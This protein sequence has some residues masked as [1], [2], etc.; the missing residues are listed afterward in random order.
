MIRNIP[1]LS[2][3]DVNALIKLSK[4]K[5]P[6]AAE[7]HYQK[8]RLLDLDA[9]K[10]FFEDSEVISWQCITE[11]SA[12]CLGY[13]FEKYDLAINDDAKDATG[14]LRFD[15]LEAID[16]A[17]ADVFGTYSWGLLS[18]NGLQTLS[19]DCAKLLSRVPWGQLQLNGLGAL[20]PMGFAWLYTT[21]DGVSLDGLRVLDLEHLNARPTGGGGGSGGGP[22]WSIG[23]NGIAY[24][25]QA[26]QDHLGEEG[27]CCRDE[28]KQYA[29]DHWI[30]LN[31]LRVLNSASLA[32]EAIL[33]Q[34]DVDFA[35]VDVDFTKLESVTFDAVQAMVGLKRWR[36]E[37][38]LP[39]LS[40]L[41]PDV[42]AVFCSNCD[43]IRLSGVR[44][45]SDATA[46][47]LAPFQGEELA[48]DGVSRLSEV[49][50][51][52]LCKTYADTLSLGGLVTL[53]KRQ[54][55]IIAAAQV[56]TMSL[57]S[58]SG[59]SQDV[60]DVLRTAKCGLNLSATLQQ[61]GD[62][63]EITV[64]E[65]LTLIK[66]DSP[67]WL[68]MVTNVTEEVARVLVRYEGPALS[69]FGLTAM[70]QWLATILGDCK[71]AT[72]DLRGLTELPGPVAKGLVKY[73]GFLVL[74]GIAHLSSIALDKLT[75]FR[76]NGISLRGI[77]RATPEELRKLLSIRGIELRPDWRAS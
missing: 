63:R 13:C 4:S 68:P 23:L 9:G 65:A 22:F 32:K 43:A 62:K 50:L 72:L 73:S 69:L 28:G 19:V 2:L 67:L 52:S 8:F 71:A 54:A 49:A 16:E 47:A 24:L 70:D 53:T 38:D 75:E 21:Y 66:T 15:G 25:P 18:L 17:T 61:W 40:S 1:A 42:A 39:A 20:E 51:G 7:A 11:I 33:H 10:A 37:I 48:L 3:S 77:T 12:E 57:Q 35:C 59:I 56:H 29:T 36:R 34:Y 30:G 45:L 6:N 14:K 60:A 31:G 64:A 5:G 26:W 58:V 27:R 44:E 41:S 76:G 46:A 55:E 74:D